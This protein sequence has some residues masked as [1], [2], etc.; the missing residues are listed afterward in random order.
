MIAPL[1]NRWLEL[2]LLLL[3]A[4]LLWAA[5]LP[6]H[7]R[8]AGRSLRRRLAPLVDRPRL[9]VL[10]TFLL[11]LALRAALLPFTGI[12]HP[13]VPDEFS[14]LLGADTFA[15]GRL[16]NPTPPEWEHFETPFVILR[17]SYASMYPPAQALVLA[18][19]QALT[20]EPWW[21]V[22]LSVG[23]M[24][25]AVTWM[26]QGWLPRGWALC[27]GLYLA[28]R[29]GVYSYWINSY[30]GGAVAAAG[31]ALLLGALPR[32]L[33]R[34]RVSHALLLGLGV[35][36]LAGS[37]PY[38]GL[39][40]AAP[41][42]V[43]LLAGLARRAPPRA[44][45]RV[46]LP[47]VLVLTATGA[48]I[49]LY[50]ARV[51]GDPLRMPYD[52]HRVAYGVQPNLVWQPPVAAVGY[53]HA[54]LGHVFELWN[55]RYHAARTLQGFRA[56][57]LGKLQSLWSFFGALL[58]LPALLCV[59]RALLAR[60]ARA[61][62]ALLAVALLGLL[63]E[64]SFFPHYAAPFSALFV[65]VLVLGARRLAA[66]RPGGR[67]LG[68][69]FLAPAA[70]AF[71]GLAGLRGVLEARGAPVRFWAHP[72]DPWSRRP[73]DEK[74]RELVARE[75]LA[76]GGAHLVFL[77]YTA[78][79]HHRKWTY[80]AADLAAA[81]ILWASELDPERDRRLVEAFPGRTVW[82]AFPDATPPEL[83]PHPGFP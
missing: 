23:A 32:V 12:P 16:A 7:A 71:L 78:E 20:G 14:Y 82:L 69:A 61:P 36:L 39:V 62:A 29:L 8:R 24:C 54:A 10:A 42:A 63:Q 72:H 81:P 64:V 76:R 53:G 59:P 30:W 50:D 79:I 38:E 4:A 49:G 58:L 75:L 18:A 1:A 6:D 28:L 9:A 68:R 47:I 67:R 74:D 66:W 46:V 33:A 22:W 43:L 55:E 21:G 11:P 13:R 83:V 17:P 40:L 35:A 2:E 34:P 25:A 37:R 73:H 45:T 52:V 70:L 56:A 27:G 57:S 51:T 48:W 26:L 31:G 41:A 80:N 15:A 44:L 5:V 19:A 77:R 3:A 60:R 65:L